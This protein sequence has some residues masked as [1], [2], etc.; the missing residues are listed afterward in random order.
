MYITEILLKTLP[1]N[2][3]REQKHSLKKNFS[4]YSHGVW[5]ALNVNKQ[6]CFR[7]RVTLKGNFCTRYS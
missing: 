1:K 7:S 5:N 4:K 6:L 2:M 3:T